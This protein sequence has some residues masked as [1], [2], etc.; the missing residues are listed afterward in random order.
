[1]VPMTPPPSFQA[2]APATAP[3]R[4]LLMVVP[5]C[6]LFARAP[7]RTVRCAR[8]ERNGRHRIRP[9]IELMGRSV[10]SPRR[11]A[12]TN[13]HS[14]SR[15]PNVPMTP[16]SL[17]CR[18]RPGGAW[19]AHRARPV[20]LSLGTL[21]IA[22]QPD[23]K[24]ETDATAEGTGS[25]GS[26]GTTERQPRS[27]KSGRAAEDIVTDELVFASRGQIPTRVA[28]VDEDAVQRARIGDRR[29]APAWRSGRRLPGDRAVRCAKPP[30][31]VMLVA[32]VG[33]ATN[34]HARSSAAG[35]GRSGAV[36]RRGVLRRWWAFM[37]PRRHR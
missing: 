5:V 23:D 32:T 28:D 35:C 10:S 33:V 13:P 37:R 7:A 15:K 3:R 8:L 2:P 22:C 6:P 26:S 21:P 9:N 1:M 16:Y 34:G 25:S 36:S 20:L 14:G 17:S 19:G 11:T 31:V 12:L 4:S 24:G 29:A 30:G 18:V 27:P